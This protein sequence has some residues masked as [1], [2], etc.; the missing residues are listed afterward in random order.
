MF[1]ALASLS[2][3]PLVLMF[4]NRLLLVFSTGESKAECAHVSSSVDGQP[5]RRNP[6]GMASSCRAP[7][8]AGRSKEGKMWLTSETVI[9]RVSL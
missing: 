4:R 9:Q 5:L 1:S 7:D 8:T 6:D 3:S 2:V